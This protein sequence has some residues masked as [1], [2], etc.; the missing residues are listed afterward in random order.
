MSRSVYIVS[1]GDIISGRHA[2]SQRVYKIAMSLADAG[3]RVFLCALP[4]FQS[5]ATDSFEIAPGIHAFGSMPG[6][7]NSRSSLRRFVRTVASKVA[8]GSSESVLYLYPTTFIFK[9]FIYLC[10]FKYIKRIRFFCEVNELRTAIALTPA[11]SDNVFIYLRNRIKSV[12]DYI[13]YRINEL[14]IPLYDGIV[15][16]S[17]ALEQR[18]SRMARTIA[19]VPILCDADEI[20]E[21]IPSELEPGATF[22]ICFAGYIKYEKEGFDILYE[23]LSL[24]NQHHITELYLYGK[25]EENDRQLLERLADKLKLADKIHYM[26]NIDPRSLPDEFSKYH[27]LILP[28]PLNKRTQYGFSTKLSEYL[29]SGV[30]V[31]VTDV[32]DNA[33]YIK[34]GHNGYIIEPGSSQVMADKIMDVIGEYNLKAAAIVNNAHITVREE[35][36]YRL[37]AKTYTNLFW[38]GGEV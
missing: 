15:V 37:Y 17:T 38:P 25:L 3:I 22:R 1:T 26:G 13:R 32:S 4:Y 11:P 19:R 35:L 14:Q 2:G 7:D 29:V 28:R 30:P 6:S 31:L 27:L 24:V 34:D 10:Y 9:D 21:H 18:F 8:S 5:S 16:I 20:V 36:D 12:F 23:S 33:I